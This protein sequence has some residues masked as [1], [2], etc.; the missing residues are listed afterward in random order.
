MLGYSK[1]DLHEPY[2][3]P[4]QICLRC[5]ETFYDEDAEISRDSF[6]KFLKNADFSS[7]EASDAEFIKYGSMYGTCDY[8]SHMASKND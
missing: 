4:N 6:K 5:Q 1:H 8:C 2:E 7:P 3:E